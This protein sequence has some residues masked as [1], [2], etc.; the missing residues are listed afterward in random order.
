MG[1]GVT[2][3]EGEKLLTHTGGID[4]FLTSVTIMPDK[5]LAIVLFENNTIVEPTSLA[6]R[7]WQHLL[8]K[9]L[10]DWAREEQK[11]KQSASEEAKKVYPDLP[12]V[13]VTRDLKVYFGKF[14]NKA[15]GQ[16]VVDKSE[17]PQASVESNSNPPKNVIHLKLRVLELNLI[18]VG[19]NR[20]QMP[21][22]YD[23]LKNVEFMEDSQHSITGLKIQIERSSEKPQEFI[24][25]D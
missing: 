11:A 1:W 15:Y 16:M 25:C 10:K 18:P 5:N 8:G 17:M 14:C 3:F 4:G 9:E 7:L 19:Q 6:L 2:Q 24:R 23:R 13:E 21:G 12:E 22:V 20:F